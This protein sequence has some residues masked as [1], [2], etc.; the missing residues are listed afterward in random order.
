LNRVILKTILAGTFILFLASCSQNEELNYGVSDLN[1]GSNNPIDEN[2]SENNSSDNITDNN[3]KEN[4]LEN[5]DSGVDID[6]SAMS[7]E[8]YAKFQASRFVDTANLSASQTKE[9]D[10]KDKLDELGDQIASEAGL[11]SYSKGV[12]TS[13]NGTKFSIVFEKDKAKLGDIIK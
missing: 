8:E 9:D 2:I 3:S 4:N 11:V 1:D 10:I 13:E 6:T 5:S 12:F 7:N